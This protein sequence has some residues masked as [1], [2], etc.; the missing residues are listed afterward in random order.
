MVVVCQFTEYLLQFS[1]L[2]GADAVLWYYFHRLLMQI[3]CL[4]LLSLGFNV[5][6][7]TPT[8]MHGSKG[9]ARQQDDADEHG[10]YFP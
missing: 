9:N 2:K 7:R 8:E 5:I 3:G 6:W 4:N 1:I 10:C